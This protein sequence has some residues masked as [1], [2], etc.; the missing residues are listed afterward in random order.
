M[1]HLEHYQKTLIEQNIDCL[2]K[3][4]LDDVPALAK[5]FV[6][7]EKDEVF[8]HS[9]FTNHIIY[10]DLTFDMPQFEEDDLT[11]RPTTVFNHSRTWHGQEKLHPE[12]GIPPIA[13][14]RPWNFACPLC[15]NRKPS[16]DET[17]IYDPRKS[18]RENAKELFSIF[19]DLAVNPRIDEKKRIEE[20]ILQIHTG[21]Q[22]R[23]QKNSLRVC[24]AACA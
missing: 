2:P 21:L 15:P 12:L 13:C 17:V 19:K 6:V 4:T 1:L 10:A 8:S 16:S 23:L 22:N 3:V 5:H 18:L 14:R 9:C 24:I 7:K 20:L 11:L